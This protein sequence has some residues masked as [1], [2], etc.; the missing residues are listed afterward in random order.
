[1]WPVILLPLLWFAPESPWW[2]VRKDRLDEAERI[3][4]RITDPSMHDEAPGAV[5]A[6]VRTNKLELE[7]MQGEQP[8][9]ID[10][11]KGVDLRR[12]EISA[13]AWAAQVMSGG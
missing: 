10:C 6:M 3:V 8:R 11:F 9:W 2:L 1:M 4:R 5:A 13:I 7:A 12:T